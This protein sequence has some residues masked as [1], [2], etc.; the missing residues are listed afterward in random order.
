MESGAQPPLDTSLQDEVERLRI[1]APD[2]KALYREVASMLFFRFGIAPTA[3]RLHQL[4]GKGSM[5]TAA[6]VLARF[7]QDLRQ[8]GRVRLEHPAVPEQLRDLGGNLIGQLW[9]SA[10]DQAH[11]DL[12]KA[13]AE[14]QDEAERVH[15]ELAQTRQATSEAEA[16]V[17]QLAGIVQDLKTEIAKRDAFVADRERDNAQLRAE[18]AALRSSLA[19]RR[20]EVEESRQRLARDLEGLRVAIAL[21]EER[22]RGNER[23]A[24]SEVEVARRAAA[25]TVKTMGLERKRFEA[26][27]LQDKKLLVKRGA[28]VEALRDRLA[29]S[30]ASLTQVSVQFKAE[31][32]KLSALLRK[33]RPASSKSPSRSRS[34]SAPKR[35]AVQDRR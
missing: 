5:T 14:L 27:K 7:W 18:V 13:R 10:F 12:A 1:L 31:Q 15:R 30:E 6:S 23:R 22:A 33:M 35:I 9:R 34:R 3:N 32:A 24:L 17:E 20:D 29:R 25:S 21:T 2:T 26:E 28:E 8:H 19:E 11:E 4:V 16:R